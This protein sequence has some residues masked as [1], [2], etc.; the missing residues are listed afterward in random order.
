MSTENGHATDNQWDHLYAN[1]EKNLATPLVLTA[2]IVHGFKRGSKELGIPTANLDM[3]EVEALGHDMCTGI[4]YGWAK[5]HTNSEV[6]RCVVSVGWNPYYKNEK[7]T[8]E[9]HLFAT[10]DDFYGEK[11]SVIVCGYLRDECNFSSLE[12]L[13]SCIQEDIR[14]SNVHLS[15]DADIKQF[16]DAAEWPAIITTAQAPAVAVA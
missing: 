7:K 11:L 9:A 16:A 15:G 13:I 12:E 5:L 1:T 6:Y 4:Y 14:R 8:I 2:N 3:N 10:L